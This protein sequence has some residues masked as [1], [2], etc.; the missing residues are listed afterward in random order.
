MNI[1]VIGTGYVGLV[2][3]TG[4][5][6][7]GMRV[8]CVDKNEQKIQ[9]LQQGGIP[10]FELG[11][12]DLI[13]KN[14]Q[15]QR[16]FFT[17]DLVKAVSESEIIYIGVGTPE[18]PDG[19]TN[20]TYLHAV[21]DQI[22]E[23]MT[24]HKI[25]VIKSTVP[26]GTAESLRQRIRANQKSPVSFDIVSNP[27]FLREGS[28][29]KDFLNPERVIIGADNPETM[30]LMKQIYQSL[31]DRGVPLVCTDNK[32]AELI[33]Y[34]ANTMLALKI[35]FINELSQICD[36]TGAD[37]YD[38]ARAIG[39]DQ[40][41]GPQFLQAGPGF[42]GSCFPKDV[43][44]LTKETDRLG[45]EFK[46]GNAVMA[47]NR[48]QMESVVT[49]SLK[50]LKDIEHPQITLLGVSFKP[51]TDDTREA[52]AMHIAA[53]LLK[54]NIK[55]KAYDPVAMEE[56]ARKL[57]DIQYCNNT[58]E[59]CHDSDLIL[60]ATEWTE[61]RNLNLNELHAVV[62]NPNLYDTRNI[63]NKE[64]VNRA[65]FRYFSTGRPDDFTNLSS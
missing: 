32:T 41:I 12:K 53:K 35:S 54:Q 42:G 10:I 60:I 21:I 7:F 29:I 24:E 47:V 11:L 49:K 5:A 8:T 20:L 17:T 1:A 56:A 63:Y 3:G 62:R 6:E 28:A 30:N 44:S 27:E 64:Q 59:A 50:I 48:Q 55:I 52:P 43:K 36:L 39:M 61:F 23:I 4:L 40:R 65:G 33:K 14:V 51:N 34:A 46:I 26:V 57:P 25:L 22:T 2:T 15:E 45:Y 38:V 37:I 58:V 18:N 9:I 16:L 31:A 19:T 13:K